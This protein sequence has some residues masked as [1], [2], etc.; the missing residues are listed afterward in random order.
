MDLFMNFLNVSGKTVVLV[1]VFIKHV[2]SSAAG[3][4]FPP[5]I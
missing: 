5:D 1:V 2:P 4:F 3:L